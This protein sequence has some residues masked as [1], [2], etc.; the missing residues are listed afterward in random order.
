MTRDTAKKPF[1]TRCCN[2]G[3]YS[4][5]TCPGCYKDLASKSEGVE[6]CGNCGREVRLTLEYEPVCVA[7]LV[8]DGDEA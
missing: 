3:V 2:S 5:W 7:E 1:G 6:T 8:T 4:N